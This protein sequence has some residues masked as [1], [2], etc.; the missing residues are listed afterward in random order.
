[1]SQLIIDLT[2]G[3][4]LACANEDNARMLLQMLYDMMPEHERIITTAYHQND[5]K[6]LAFEVHKLHGGV[7]YCGVPRLKRRIAELEA[8]LKRNDPFEKA[9]QD[10]IKEIAA[11]K[12]EF[13]KFKATQSA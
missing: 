5:L 4:Q 6:T 12:E 10:A 3:K 8:T 11:F 13:P 2:I 9:Y 1:M 7:S